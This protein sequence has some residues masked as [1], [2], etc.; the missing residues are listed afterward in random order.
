MPSRDNTHQY[1]CDVRGYCYKKSGDGRKARLAYSPGDDPAIQ[2][3]V[4]GQHKN[5][6]KSDL[7]PNWDDSGLQR[8]NNQADSTHRRGLPTRGGEHKAYDGNEGHV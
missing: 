6:T 2:K 4:L 3:A 1:F 7:Y 8:Y 5:T